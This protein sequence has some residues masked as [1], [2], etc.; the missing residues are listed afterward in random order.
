MLMQEN[1]SL[2]SAAEVIAISKLPLK[3]A[4]YRITNDYR[5]QL[6]YNRIMQDA[7]DL[8]STSD[9]KKLVGSVPLWI[10][11]IPG[12][13]MKIMVGYIINKPLKIMDSGCIPDRLGWLWSSE[14]FIKESLVYLSNEG[15]GFT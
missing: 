8:D 4:L 10:N 12:C 15:V 1:G 3:T 14:P 6:S 9:W 7:V 5:Y 2:F 11:F 13:T